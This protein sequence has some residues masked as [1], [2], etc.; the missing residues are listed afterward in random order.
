MLFPG[1]TAQV[2]VG[3][4]FGSTKVL[5][6]ALDR[7][8]SGG[9]QRP[10]ANSRSP[11]GRTTR[12]AKGELQGFLLFDSLAQGRMTTFRVRMVY[13]LGDIFEIRIAYSSGDILVA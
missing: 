10:K 7:S 11:S 3:L 13:R 1:M 12:K 9:E 2:L 4:F 6:R 5:V 8:V